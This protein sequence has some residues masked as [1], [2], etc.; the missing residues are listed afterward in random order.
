M[1]CLF[2]LQYPM[3]MTKT[4]AKIMIAVVWVYAVGTATTPLYGFNN[5]RPGEGCDF[6]KVLPKALTI[7]T[8]PVMQCLSLGATFVLYLKIFSVA[9]ANKKRIDSFKTKGNYD[10]KKMKRDTKNAKVTQRSR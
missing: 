6:W 8:V 1:A 7:P 10:E 3:W 2:H 4:R 9:K 5:W